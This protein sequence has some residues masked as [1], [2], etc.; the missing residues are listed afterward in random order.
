[1]ECNSCSDYYQ[2]SNACVPL[3]RCDSTAHTWW[4]QALL[5]CSGSQHALRAPDILPWPS[6]SVAQPGSMAHSILIVPWWLFSLKTS[7]PST[8]VPVSHRHH[9]GKSDLW[10]SKPAKLCTGIYVHITKTTQLTGILNKKPS[11]TEMISGV[12]LAREGALVILFL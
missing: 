12:F 5:L 4:L 10:A 9:P 7:G 1:M 2:N 3:Q 6:S 8:L 11:S